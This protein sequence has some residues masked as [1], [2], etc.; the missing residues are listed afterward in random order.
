MAIE[1]QLLLGSSKTPILNSDHTTKH[2]MSSR[3]TYAE[4]LAKRVKIIASSKQELHSIVYL[5][6]KL[7]RVEIN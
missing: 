6:K 4:I 7:E 3:R 5:D 1:L 2:K